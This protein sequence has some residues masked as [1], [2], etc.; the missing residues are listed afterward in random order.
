MTVIVA[1]TAVSG[2]YHVTFAPDGLDKLPVVQYQA[3]VK[4]S[5]SGSEALQVRLAFPPASTES[6]PDMPDM[7]GGLFCWN[8]TVMAF[9]AVSAACPSLTMTVTTA[10]AALSGAYQVTLGPDWLDS[11]PVLQDHA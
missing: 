8:R 5:P 9:V 6:G 2:A 10:D 11:P 1:N 4:E 3:Y 7:V